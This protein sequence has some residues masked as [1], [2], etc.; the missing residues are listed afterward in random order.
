MP[1][2][3]FPESP[4]Y[5]PHANGTFAQ[6]YFFDSSYYRAGGPVL[7]YLSGETSGPSRFGN[8]QSGIVQILMQVTGGLGVILEN[9]YY[10]ASYPVA[11][12]TTDAL[13]YLTNEQ[14]VADVAYFARH[15]VFPGVGDGKLDLTA[16][17][18]PWILYGGSLAGAQTA[19]ALKT[20]GAALLYGGIASSAPIVAD[21]AYPQ[22]YDV[23]QR[24]GPPDCVAA[25]NDIVDRLDV[26]V[27]TG[28][29]AAIRQLK[30]IFGLEAL[31]DL[32]DFAAA[33]AFPLGGPMSYPTDSWQELDWQDQDTAFW[34]FCRN[35]TDLDA[36]PDRA[37]VDR[38]MAAHSADGKPWAYLG[39][40]ADYIKK[41]IVAALP[42]RRGR[43]TCASAPRTPL[44]GPTRATAAAAPTSLPPAPRAAS[45]RRP[46]TDPRR[47]TL[48][49]RVLDV[50]Y[51]QQWCDWAFPPGTHN[52]IPPTPDVGRWNSY[53][54]YSLREVDRLAF[55]DGSIDPW[56]DVCYHSSEPAAGDGD[57][58]YYSTDLHPAYLIP[59]AG[60]H[61]DSSGIRDVAAEPQFIRETHLWEIRTVKKW[62]RDFPAWKEKVLA[63]KATS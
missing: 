17:A 59:G 6:R 7:L 63:G 38:A 48:V 32:R 3:H 50:N 36:P 23:I 4:R 54:T 15:A 43:S 31:A 33:I 57:D 11:V 58:R 51:T 41:A 47:K 35:L 16:P 10:G 30:A 37:A 40:Y 14:T 55:V 24:S 62:L 1:V 44:C 18:T 56:I 39:N 8:L 28:A 49:S 42:G 9:R 5:R 26:L 60:H 22:W 52:A 25:V 19:F 46:G 21:V 13:A 53:G 34:A 20:H 29:G 27:A 12:S 45:T 2:D 61:W